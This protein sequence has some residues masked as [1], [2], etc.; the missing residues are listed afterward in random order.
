MTTRTTLNISLPCRAQVVRRRARRLT[1]LCLSKRSE[2]TALRLLEEA[3]P[4]WAATSPAKRKS[5]RNTACSTGDW[6]MRPEPRV[7]ISRASPTSLLWRRAPRA[8]SDRDTRLAQRSCRHAILHW[9]K[10]LGV[11]WWRAL[12]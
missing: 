7:I 11:I 2:R 8:Q 3:T 6:V 4:T 1:S 12:L 9:R 5:N 10:W